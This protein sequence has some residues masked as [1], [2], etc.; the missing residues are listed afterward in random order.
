MMKRLIIVALLTAITAVPTSAAAK[1]FKDSD[2]NWRAETKCRFPQSDS[3]RWLR[4]EDRKFL[5]IQVRDGDIGKCPTDN[6]KAHGEQFKKPHSERAEIRGAA[7]RQTG[8][9]KVSFD[10]RFVQGFDQDRVSTTFFQI[11]DCP[12]SRVPVMAMLGGSKKRNGGPA[13]FGF[14]LA[15]GSHGKKWISKNVAPDPVDNKWHTLEFIFE[16]YSTQA[17]TVTVDGKTW[18]PRTTFLNIFYCGRPTL[19]LGIYRAGDPGRN[20]HS[21]IDYDKIRVERLK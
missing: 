19:D 10:V 18:L 21:I 13:K 1:S 4:E 20:A 5:R 2:W 17:L 14:S 12:D 7:F 8:T 6:D 15:A 3:A 16:N 9:Y 11:K